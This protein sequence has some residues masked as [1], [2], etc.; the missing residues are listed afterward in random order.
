[1]SN[2]TLR[3]L[4]RD[5][6][7]GAIDKETY[8][9]SRTELVTA[10]ISG[11]V[12]VKANAYEPP[13]MPVE[14][15]LDVTET[16]Q[17]DRDTTAFVDTN[18]KSSA[19][20]KKS[21]PAQT[22]KKSPLVF[23]IVSAVIVIS[24]II[25][26]FLFY[27]KPPGATPEP[28]SSEQLTITP[29]NSAQSDAAAVMNTNMAGESLIA[30]FLTEK[31][32]TEDGLDKFIT[33]WSALTYEEQDSAKQTKRMQRMHDSIYKQFLEEKALESIDSEKAI[34]KQEKLIEFATAIG[35]SDSRLSID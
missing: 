35:I 18:A 27:P 34:M 11:K 10:I 25:A 29:T 7:K 1:M 13:L 12:A 16:L 28:I 14:E 20:Q 8:R 6:A 4:A 9:K 26:V 32:W 24:L 21:V 2:K 22:D 19:T 3:E 17:R 30:D 5:Y 23:I 31:N 15:D 33:E